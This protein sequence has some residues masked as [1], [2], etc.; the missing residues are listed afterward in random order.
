M[1]NVP[2]TLGQTINGNLSVAGQVDT[3]TFSGTP[4]QRLFF[5]GQGDSTNGNI[6]A[7]LSS[8]SGGKPP[9][10]QFKRR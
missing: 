10:N 7:T 4:G 6:N 8:P 9:G 1:N 5:D 3:Y 2:Y